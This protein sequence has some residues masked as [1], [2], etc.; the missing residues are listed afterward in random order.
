[1][2]GAGQAFT[3]PAWPATLPEI[4]GKEALP[5]AMSLAQAL[6][7]LAGLVGSG[8]AGLMV[9]KFGYVAP[10]VT[11]AVTFTVL[12]LAPAFFALSKNR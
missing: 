8:L 12:A 9:G 10:M 5:Q 3:A 1:M 6:Y 11:D 7:S 2:L 4:L